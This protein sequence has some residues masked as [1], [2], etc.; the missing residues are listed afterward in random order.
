MMNIYDENG[1]VWRIY[2]RQLNQWSPLF[3]TTLLFRFLAWAII[4]PINKWYAHNLAVC[5][6]CRKQGH[7]YVTPPPYIGVYWYVFTTGHAQFECGVCY[8]G[9]FLGYAKME[10]R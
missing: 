1:I 6:W 10:Y 7:M 3:H 8:Q 2:E 5:P 9:A 4:T